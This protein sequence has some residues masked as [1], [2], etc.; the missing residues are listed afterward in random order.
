VADP[1]LHLLAGPNGAGKTTFFREILGPA[2]GLEFVNADELAAMIWPGTEAEH[3][4][5]ASDLARAERDRRIRELR[6]FA[7]ETVF[8]HPSKVD[9][10]RRAEAAGYRVTLH[11]VL[12]PEDLAVA[13]VRSRVDQGGHDAP[14]FKIRERFHRL[15]ALLAEA[16]GAADEALVYDNTRAAEPFRRVASFIRGHP[17]GRPDWPPWTP[18]DLRAIAVG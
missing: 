12:I 2:T 3:A 1:V 10:V 17:V 13:R 9:L 5:D 7:T 14:E 8:S 15:W 16:I 6:S 18:D 4:Y 11:V